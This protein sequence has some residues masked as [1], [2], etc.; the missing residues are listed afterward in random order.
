MKTH[1]HVLRFALVS[2]GLLLA[3]QACGG[4]PPVTPPVTAVIGAAGGTLS[5]SSGAK[6]VIPPGA[7]SGNITIGSENLGRVQ[8]GS[9]VAVSRACSP[10]QP[11]RW[12]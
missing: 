5:T 11:R 3:L 12:R 4:A 7:L 10:P 2:A 8:C 9:R 6:V 1:L